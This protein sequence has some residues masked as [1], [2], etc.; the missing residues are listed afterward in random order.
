MAETLIELANPDLYCLEPH[1]PAVR[2]LDHLRRLRIHGAPVVDAEGAP[3]GVITAIDLVG[4]LE[5]LRVADRMSTPA[6]TLPGTTPIADAARALAGSRRHHV[7][8][9]DDDTTV[10]F[11]SSL[12][13]LA[14][15][16]GIPPRRPPAFPHEPDQF[17]LAWDE[18]R[19]L[20]DDAIA[21]APEGPGVLVLVHGG[22]YRPEDVVWAEQSEHLRRRLSKLWASPSERPEALESWIGWGSLRFVTAQTRDA[23]QRRRALE[24]IE[25]WIEE[26]RHQVHDLLGHHRVR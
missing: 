16:M 21:H 25:R 17:G 23:D 5:G 1:Q 22:A 2:A 3:L 6:A 19:D 26:G 11:V 7:V 10:G 12:D 18:P 9:V 8:V 20:D 24:A 14:A 13:L 15:V 4:N